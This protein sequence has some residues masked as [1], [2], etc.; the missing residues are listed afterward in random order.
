MKYKDLVQFE[1]I[2]TVVQLREADDKVEATNLVRTYVI[3]FPQL[4][5][6]FDGLELDQVLVLHAPISSYEGATIAA[7][8]RS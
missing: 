5:N 2:E 8:G 6:G 4:D 1:P 7:S 3:C